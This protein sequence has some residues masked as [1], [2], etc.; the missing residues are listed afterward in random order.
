[1]DD[2]A[3]RTFIPGWYPDP[4]MSGTLRYWDGAKWT[5]QVAPIPA[6]RPPETDRTVVQIVTAM[7]IAAS[8]GGL[9]LSQQSVSVM[10][11]SGIIW[12]GVALCGGASV[13]TWVVGML[14]TWT[15]AVAGLAAAVAL[16]T[17]WSVESELDDRRQE[18]G[19]LLE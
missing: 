17:A 9:I 5:D 8:V 16:L 13:V 2:K 3:A 4:R 11:G 10:T 19:N 18:I 1:M 7:V 6:Q 15:R 14:P 12:V